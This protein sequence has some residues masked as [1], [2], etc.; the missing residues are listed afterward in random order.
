MP[1][2]KKNENGVYMVGFDT[3]T[4]FKWR[5]TKARTKAE[6]EKVVSLA[7]IPELEMA[8]RAKALTAESLSAI[9][10]GRKVTCATAFVEWADWM[11]T[12][13]SAPNTI[14]TYAGCITQ[15]LR[16]NKLEPKPV[17]AITLEMIMEFVN[18]DDAGSRSN[19]NHRLSAIRSLFNL[20][21]SRAYCIGDAS[22]AAKI[23]HRAMTAEQKERKK[24]VPFTEFEFRK[25]V[26]HSDGFW[27]WAVQLGWW[28]GLRLSDICTLEWSAIKDG[29]IVVHTLKRDARVALPIDHEA[30]GGGVLNMVLMEMSEHRTS[31]RFCFPEAARDIMDP[32]KRSKFSV[33]F[34]RLLEKLG[35]YN[36]SFHCLRHSFVSRLNADGVDLEKIGELVGHRSKKITEGYVTKTQPAV[37]V[38]QD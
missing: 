38:L 15:F 4:G 33:A 31:S 24:R 30:I 28:T 16:D 26:A 9:M 1:E 8:A 12:R 37:A 20:C 32:K 19:R 27:N 14:D 7:R 18:S 2:L 3:D 5:S 21:T 22:R 17:T 34:M 23:V 13:R 6:A 11:Q 29:T 35:I 25:L 36:R 10:A